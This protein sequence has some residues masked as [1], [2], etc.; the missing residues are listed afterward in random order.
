MRIRTFFSKSI[1]VCFVAI[2]SLLLKNDTMR[3]K[4]IAK[5]S[6]KYWE[7][8][9]SII[10]SFIPQGYS[11]IDIGSG[12]QSL[13]KFLSAGCRYQPCDLITIHDHTMFCDFNS[14][15]YPKVNSPFDIVVC[16]GV[17]EYANDPL[18]VVYNLIKLGDSML[19]SY[20]ISKPNDMRFSRILRG[21]KN[22]MA[23]DEIE[24]MFIRLQIKWNLVAEWNNQNIYQLTK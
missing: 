2:K 24:G 21:W 7:K 9:N 13:K 3:W 6:P 15:I 20:A 22:H 1:K 18:A 8:R 19:L 10:A 23:S 5:E 11:V 17:L 14:E 4:N 16:S 12:N